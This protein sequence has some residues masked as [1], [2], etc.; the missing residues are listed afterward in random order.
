MYP[1]PRRRTRRH[2]DRRAF[3]RL[4]VGG[5]ALLARQPILGRDPAA[6]EPLPRPFGHGVASGEPLTDPGIQWSRGTPAATDTL[7][8]GLWAATAVAWQGHTHPNLRCV[9]APCSLR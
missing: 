7:G 5:A 9:A 8:P 2:M 3:L 6:A 1:T 4:G